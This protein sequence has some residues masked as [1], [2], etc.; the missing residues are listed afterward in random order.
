M[1]GVHLATAKTSGSILEYWSSHQLNVVVDGREHL[2]ALFNRDLSR[3]HQATWSR[4]LYVSCMLHAGFSN[5]HTIHQIRSLAETEE[6]PERLKK[7]LARRSSEHQRY[8][9]GQRIVKPIYEKTYLAFPG[10]FNHHPLI[11]GQFSGCGELFRSH[12]GGRYSG[13]CGLRT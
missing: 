2:L 1:A 13:Q 9:W 4:N 5:E 7:L 11:T 12:A 6:L 10:Q 3:V 8:S